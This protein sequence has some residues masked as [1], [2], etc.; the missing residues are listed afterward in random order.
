MCDYSLRISNDN[1]IK[2][3][4]KIIIFGATGTVG[5][6]TAIL[7]RK[8][9]YNIIAVG[10]RFSDNGFF[11]ENGI[12]YFSVDVKDASSFDV[13]PSDDVET[14]IHFAGAMP[15]T[16]NG[17]NPHE[18]IYSV[19]D[20]TLNVLE[21]TRRVGAKKIIFAQSRADSN[22]LMDKGPIPSDI[23]KK[24]PL[25]GD[26]SVYSICKN[27]A[28]DLIEHYYYQY[29]I[30]RFE[31]RFPTIYA[32]HPN[33]YFHVNGVKKMM[34]FRQIMEQAMRGDSIEVW[35]DPS[36]RKEIVYV[37]D[38]V[39]VIEKCI[40]SDLDGG[41]YNV[42]TGVP[43]TLDEQIR[44]IIDVMSPKDHKSEIIYRPD[45]PNAREFVNDISKTKRDLGYEPQ[46]SYREQLEDFLMYAKEEPFSKLWGKR[47]DYK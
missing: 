15:A 13:L 44:G 39:Q 6:Y 23:V 27:A 10:R 11:I 26:H 31:L 28:V 30:K 35:G 17:Y 8:K 46:F 7:L 14:V 4:G 12:P 41:M 45:K 21:F 32:Y 3:M 33:P 38:T 43:V 42:G 34:A 18:Y 29:G 37:K 19:L 22:Y 47:E 5:A 24:F 20:G 1:N 2:I 25:T 36:R 9:G 16:M 40:L